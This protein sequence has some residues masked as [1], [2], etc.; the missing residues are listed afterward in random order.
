MTP[1]NRSNDDTAR[2]RAVGKQ[3]VNDAWHDRTRNIYKAASQFGR[4]KSND[5]G[6]AAGGVPII[7]C[8][9]LRGTAFP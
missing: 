4:H 6:D 8:Y 2:K 1:R 5:V 7:R 3:A 9:A